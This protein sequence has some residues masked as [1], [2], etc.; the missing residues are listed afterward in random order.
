MLQPEELTIVSVRF[1]SVETFFQR[2]FFLLSVVG[3]KIDRVRVSAFD[4]FLFT[5]PS[6]NRV[7]KI[8]VFHSNQHLRK[9]KRKM[10]RWLCQQTDPL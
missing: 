5:E 2:L 7:G 9:G 10:R 3:K 1:Q 4:V 6:N 8:R